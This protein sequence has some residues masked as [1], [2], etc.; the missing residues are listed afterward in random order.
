MYINLQ[1]KAMESE[2]EIDENLA[3]IQILDV[4]QKM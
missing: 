3:L 4:V 2:D 1:G